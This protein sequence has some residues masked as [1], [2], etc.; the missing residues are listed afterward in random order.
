M[1]RPAFSVHIVK[2]VQLVT[3]TLETS[4]IIQVF[5]SL[6]HESNYKMIEITNIIQ[7]SKTIRV[8]KTIE[9]YTDVVS[10]APCTFI[11]DL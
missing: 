2:L 4:T 10:L 3:F 5:Q 7:I 1:C 8:C 6:L 11:L 9:V